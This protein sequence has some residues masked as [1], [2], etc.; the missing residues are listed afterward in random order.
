LH[1]LCRVAYTACLDGVAQKISLFRRQIDF[2]L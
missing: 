1:R 2:H